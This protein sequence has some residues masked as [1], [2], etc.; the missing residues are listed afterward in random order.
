MMQENNNFAFV[1]IHKVNF[2]YC[3]S[4]GEVWR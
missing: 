3:S 2:K 1:K 4:V